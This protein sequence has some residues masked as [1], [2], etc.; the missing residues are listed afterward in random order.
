MKKWQ[1]VMEYQFGDTV[2]LRIEAPASIST[3]ESDPTPACMRGP[4]SIWV[5][6]CIITCQV[7][8]ILFKK[9]STFMLTG[10]Q[11]FVYFHTKTSHIEKVQ[12]R[13]TKFIISL[14]K[15]SYK[16]RLMQLNLPTLKYKRLRWDIVLAKIWEQDASKSYVALLLL[17]T[18]L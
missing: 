3:S 10:Q 16:V 6:A 13:A 5:P 12:K 17:C 2:T 4:A 11:Y 8:V 18:I 15:Y 1:Q 14:K 9:S 7:C